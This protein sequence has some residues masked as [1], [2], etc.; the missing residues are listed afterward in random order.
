MQCGHKKEKKLCAARLMTFT[1][2][3]HAVYQ[4]NNDTG[5][6]E[7]CQIHYEIINKIQRNRKNYILYKRTCAC[8]TIKLSSKLWLR[9][10]YK[11]SSWKQRTFNVHCAS[12]SANYMSITLVSNAYIWYNISELDINIGHCDLKKRDALL[13]HTNDHTVVCW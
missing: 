4:T 5:L 6:Y 11:I 12:S 7:H 2:L 3:F 8:L 10:Q 1:M 13:Q 9:K